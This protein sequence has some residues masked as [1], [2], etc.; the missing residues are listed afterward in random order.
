MKDY[1]LGDVFKSN[2][3]RIVMKACDNYHQ[4]FPG[5]LAA[6]YVQRIE[7]C[8]HGLPAYWDTM[9]QI[10][11]NR[12]ARNQTLQ[13]MV[14][15]DSTL[16]IHLRTGDVIDLGNQSI[17]D[18]LLFDY[19]TSF[20]FSNQR[21]YTRSLPFYADIWDKIQSEGIEIDKILVVTGWH[22]TTDHSRSIAYINE[23]IKYFER[24]VGTV[25]LRLN[26][27][28]DEDVLMMVNSKYF[29]SAGG[30]YSQM[31]ATLVGMNGGR[32][33]GYHWDNSKKCIKK[34]EENAIENPVRYLRCNKWI[35]R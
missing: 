10:V 26:E 15:D 29:V 1:R 8:T 24:L 21:W 34:F 9:L 25:T 2:N 22:K 33:F 18:Y 30:G 27:N 28:P 20:T 19:T 35:P 14:P 11:R 12:T 13:S 7:N 6:E 3:R 23:L 32:V 16:V 31:I 5:S 4:R 17:R